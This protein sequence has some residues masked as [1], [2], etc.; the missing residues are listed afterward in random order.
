MLKTIIAGHLIAILAFAAN[1]NI[2][3]A[4]EKQPQ[5]ELNS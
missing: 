1:V 3:H 2:V 5:P 4:D